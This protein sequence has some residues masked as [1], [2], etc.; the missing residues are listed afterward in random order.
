M[1]SVTA[2][3]FAA[4]LGFLALTGTPL[5]APDWVARNV[6]ERLN[7]GLGGGR[8]SVGQLQLVV[9]R[10]VVPRVRMRNVGV[11]DQGG[12]E[13]ARLNEVGAR[14][15]K[16]AL[17]SG[18][19]EMR[20][21]QVSGA[22]ITVRR[23]ADGTFDFTLGTGAGTSGT[24]AGVLDAIEAAFARAPLAGLERVIADELTIT[25]EDSRS[26]RIWQV[27]GGKLTLD[28]EAG[29]LDLT[30]SAEVFNGTEELAST[31][32]GVTTE[33]GSAQASLTATFENATAADI[34][35]Q[36]PALSFLEVIDAP[37]SG[38]LRAALDRSGELADL[39]GTLEIGAGAVQPTPET[40]PI[41]F[42]G[43][44]AYVDYDPEE[45]RLSISGVTL[46]SAA[47]QGRAEGVAFLQDFQAG[48][49][50]AL[51]GQFSL[52]DV[53]L[54]PGKVF[55]EPMR[56]SAGAV[57]FRLRLDPLSI[58]VGQ[59]SLQE[60]DRRFLGAGTVRT[61][62]AGWGV[63]LDLALNT[64]PLDRLL[65]LWPVQIA[66]GARNW[67]ERN[68]L[69]GD[70]SELAAAFRLFPDQEPQISLSYL[71]SG[72]D[73][74]FMQTLP[75]VRDGAG[76]A[77]LTG[78]TYTMVIEKGQ[79]E[80]PQGGAIDV[81]GTVFRVP[82]ITVPEGRAELTLLTDAS[83][84]ASLSLMDL[85]PFQL[86]QKAELQPDLAEG[87]ARMR[88]EVAFNLEKE[89]ALEDVS[90]A[91]AGRLTD[92]ASDTLVKNRR[93]SAPE[94]ELIADE[95]GIT[96][97]GR[98]RLGA[99]PADVIWG[100]DF[101]PEHAGKS[102]AEGTIELSQA[103]LDEFGITLPPGS[104]TGRGAGQFEVDL[105]RGEAPK[106]TLVS[107]VNRMGLRL[108]AIDWAKPRN[109]TGRFEVSG[110][111]GERPT[112]DRLA[113]NAAGL[114]ASGVVDL[115]ETGAMARA[116]FDR[117]RVGGW[118][119]GPVTLTG[120]GAGR[121][122]AVTMSGGS[123][124]LRAARFG[125]GGG[126]GGGPL[127][128][129]LDRLVVSEGITFTNF[130]GRFDN[131]T[132]LDGQFT[133]RINGRTPV[134]G[135][136]VSTPSGAAVR[137][138][139]DDAGAAMAAAGILP[140]ARG[141][142]M[143][144][145]LNP[146]GAEGVYDGRLRVNR[147]RIVQAPALTQLLSAISIVGLLDQMNSSGITLSEVE[148]EFQLTPRRL[149]LYRSSAVGPSLGISLAGI[150]DLASGRMDMQGVLSPVYFLNAI[151]QVFS[152]RG[153][154]VFGFNFRMRGAAGNPSV[155]V[156]PLSI[157]TP[158]MFREI[159]RRPPPQPSSGQ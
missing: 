127:A 36:S 38:A 134:A 112:I 7:K 99:V 31:V 95:D 136:V 119:D 148:A 121:S 3:V 145:T 142:R 86:M 25:L 153:E 32:I 57:D 133:A 15:A 96:I 107:D 144:L 59:V 45:A 27:T 98:G 56:F 20:A 6:E 158:G 22:Q 68:T 5:T 76:Y 16:G 85:P 97:G 39:A 62:G 103:F 77:S 61:E 71:Y 156:N 151:G 69:A 26:G 91:V 102:R 108:A 72:A 58:E 18:A 94:L 137:L 47:A 79:I 152:R 19:V 115:T 24:L 54:Q 52:T 111:L 92:F 159:F 118:L 21:L 55:A 67:I 37:I 28:Q 13:V 9:D 124:D 141:G 65:A 48:W 81:A 110:R 101:G 105:V 139:S 143:D 100:Q 87:R 146:T 106:F 40:R 125:A 129:S 132:G 83:I 147:T 49:P 44:Q 117:V 75:P 135:Q 93:I 116:Q 12:A 43:A 138:V 122:P 131:G 123:I 130:A 42:D 140:N 74:K 35:A 23:R 89:V 60:E 34:A 80:A 78:K 8:V 82:D 70:I 66:P 157:L 104:I 113:L 63:A 11:F 17:A 53:S 154:G 120:R 51:V 30:V 126:G 155:T 114:S 10:S 109:Q 90:Y 2:L 128:L 46:D 88:A 33:R 50:E 1:L 14:L 64:I 29:S 4:G 73:V 150:Y 41:P 149:T 84:T